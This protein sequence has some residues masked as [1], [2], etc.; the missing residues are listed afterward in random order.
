VKYELHFGP[1][2]QIM[3]T[4]EQQDFMWENLPDD[5]IIELLDV[6]LRYHLYLN[7]YDRFLVNMANVLFKDEVH[8]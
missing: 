1:N 8:E 7:A 2:G 5:K 3:A 4:E 6:H